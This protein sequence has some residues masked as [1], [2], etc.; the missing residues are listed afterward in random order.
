VTTCPLYV[1]LSLNARTVGGVISQGKTKAYVRTAPSF[2]F[3][4][5]TRHVTEASLIKY[6]DL[7]DSIDLLWF[8]PLA[9]DDTASSGGYA[10]W[11]ARQADVFILRWL[12]D[13]GFDTS[14]L[15]PAVKKAAREKIAQ[16]R[17]TF[18]CDD[19]VLPEQFR[20]M[21]VTGAA[22]A[23]MRTRIQLDLAGTPAEPHGWDHA[24]KAVLA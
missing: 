5:V 3:H 18:A 14:E 10:P 8:R 22:R 11:V 21:G 17:R 16:V 24:R 1:A 6:C 7:S 15:I 23:L 13:P 4:D 9:A 12:D 20:A 19:R 2:G